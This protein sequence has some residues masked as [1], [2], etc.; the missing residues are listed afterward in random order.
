MNIKDMRTNTR[1]TQKDFAEY[2]N[3]PVRTLQD[4]EH[5][6]RTPSVYVVELIKYKI[7][8]ERL[9]MLKL[10]IKDHGEE[11]VIKEGTLIEIVKYLQENEDLINWVQD[12]DPEIELPDLEEVENIDDLEYELDK[13]DLDWWKLEIR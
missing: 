5:E 3:I 12:E 1:M 11:E 8:K 4:W 6:K 13:I 7:K 2:F 9:G 10:I